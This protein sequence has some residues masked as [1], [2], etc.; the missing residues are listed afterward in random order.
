MAENRSAE[1]AWLPVIGRALAHICMHNAEMSR[2][3]IG[4]KATFLT[5]LGIEPS[6]AAGMLNTT[7]ASVRELLRLARNK[8]KK[9]GP[10]KNASRKA[11]GS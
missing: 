1:E 3:T 10:K 7:E 6:H 4:E 5:A 11:K 2:K 8:T 9:R